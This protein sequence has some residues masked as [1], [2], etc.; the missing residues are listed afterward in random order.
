MTIWSKEKREPRFLWF[1][2][3][4]LFPNRVVNTVTLDKPAIIE[5]LRALR[6]EAS[7]IKAANRVYWARSVHTKLEI[8]LYERRRRRLE[9]I[10]KEARALIRHHA[11]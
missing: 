5:R 8:E 9:E 2:A 10:R 11:A 7:E 3:H 1:G 4:F 6:R